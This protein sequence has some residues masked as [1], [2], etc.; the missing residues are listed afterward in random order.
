METFTCN[1]CGLIDEPEIRDNGPHQSAYCKGCGK[2]IKH[3]PTYKEDYKLWFGKY[4]GS[5]ISEVAEDDRDYL[6]WL[7]NNAT[8]LKDQHKAAIA[9]LLDIDP[10]DD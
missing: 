6:R 5:L 10:N 1:N 3:A 4:K 9:R 2:W 8:T 7:Y